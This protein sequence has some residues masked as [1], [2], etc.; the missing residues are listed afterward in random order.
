MEVC[1]AFIDA[2]GVLSGPRRLQ[3]LYGIGALVVPDNRVAANRLYRLHFNF[4]AHLRAARRHIR[5][6][7]RGS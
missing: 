6:Q 1:P 5:H 2:T 4:I 3:P 7:V